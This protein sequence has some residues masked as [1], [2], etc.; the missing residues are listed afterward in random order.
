MEKKE[1]M[2]KNTAILTVITLIAGLLLGFVHDIT[3]EPIARQEALTLANGQKAVFSDAASFEEIALDGDQVE[4]LLLEEGLT[5]T[6]ANRLYEAKGE[7]GGHLGYVVDVTNME[8]YGGDIQILVGIRTSE[9]EMT[10][11]GIDFLS[12]SETAGMGMKAKEPP[13]IDAFH[14]LSADAVTVTGEEEGAAKVDAIS[15]ATI[16]SKGVCKAVNAALCVV[17]MQEGVL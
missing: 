12:L 17:Q 4:A 10:I 9:G 16:T 1:S 6:N 3:A 7:D 11:N 14:D 13:F 5:K 15:G 8:G 2:W